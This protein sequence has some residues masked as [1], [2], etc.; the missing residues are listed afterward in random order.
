MPR[1]AMGVRQRERAES[2]RLQ[3]ATVD[4]SAA[5]T[6]LGLATAVGIYQKVVLGRFVLSWFPQ[7]YDTFPFLAPVYTVTEPYLRFFRSKIPGIAGFDVSS[8]A[9]FFVLDIAGNAAASLGCEIPADLEER[10]QR[11]E[12]AKRQQACM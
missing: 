8:I 12:V 1:L 4:P 2:M 10:L 3:L 9:A 6:G 7:L 11:L 5:Y